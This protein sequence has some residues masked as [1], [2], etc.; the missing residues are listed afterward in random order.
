MSKHKIDSVYTQMLATKAQVSKTHAEVVSLKQPH[1]Q[2]FLPTY[3]SV[4]SLGCSFLLGFLA[5]RWALKNQTQ[6]ENLKIGSQKNHSLEETHKRIYSE[7]VSGLYEFLNTSVSNDYNKIH[8]F[9]YRSVGGV[10]ASLSMEKE[11]EQ[12]SALMKE[13]YER[14]LV[15][16]EKVQVVYNKITKLSFEYKYIIGESQVIKLMQEL[17]SHINGYADESVYTE[18]MHQ[19]ILAKKIDMKGLLQI[20]NKELDDSAQ[21]HEENFK[22]IIERMEEVMLAETKI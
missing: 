17:T 9:Y 6:I 21:L 19:S 3:V 2:K 7:L 22:P 14:M 12:Y 20:R 10:Y 5:S 11:K 1:I 15:S 16:H 18:L 4:L 8:H 13:A